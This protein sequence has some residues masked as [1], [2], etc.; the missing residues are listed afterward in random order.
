MARPTP[1]FPEVGSTIVPGMQ[2]SR[3]LRP[4]R[5]SAARS[6]PSLSRRVEVLHLGQDIGRRAGAA[7]LLVNPA[8]PEQRSVPTSSTRGVV[9]LHRSTTLS[10][11]PLTLS[12][13][14][15]PPAAV[16]GVRRRSKHVLGEGQP[17]MRRCISYRRV[18]YRTSRESPWPRPFV[19]AVARSPIGRAFKGSMTTIRPDDLDR[20]DDRRRAGQGTPAR[21]L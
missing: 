20:A 6:G 1:V 10:F 17:G 9:H 11:G 21:P 3:R 15:G 13:A 2:L 7:E 18:N 14:S 16:R 12:H 4:P 19:V 5:S 8:Q